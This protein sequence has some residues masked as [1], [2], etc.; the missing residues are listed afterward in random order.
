MLNPWE[1]IRHWKSGGEPVGR[2]DRPDPAPGDC[3]SLE[4]L[5][6]RGGFS[7]GRAMHRALANCA[8]QFRSA[9]PGD[10]A[11][12]RYPVF[13]IIG[14]ASAV[15]LN[16]ENLSWLASLAPD[17]STYYTT[18]SEGVARRART[19]SGRSFANG[20]AVHI[21]QIGGINAIAR[22]GVP[23]VAHLHGQV[24]AGDGSQLSVYDSR[25]KRF[26]EIPDAR[27]VA[28]DSLYSRALHLGRQQQFATVDPGAAGEGSLRDLVLE[29][30]DSGILTNATAY[31]AVESHAQWRMLEEAEKQALKAR[32]GLGF[33]EVPPASSVPE[34]STGLLVLVSGILLALRRR[35]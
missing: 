3:E 22:S 25:T 16:V 27:W 12:E 11:F 4:Q 29:S 10:S 5:P 24:G 35:R 15:D 26:S 6:R 7:A 18:D 1:S 19:V 32:K 14:A 34:P 31:I 23:S 21:F 8:E 20:S 13:M 17:F 30:R 2:W 28:G 9:L 33:A